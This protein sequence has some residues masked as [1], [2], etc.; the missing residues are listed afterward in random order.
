MDIK[1]TDMKLEKN[2]IVFG[3]VIL[4]MVLFIVGYA[5]MALGGDEEGRGH[6]GHDAAASSLHLHL[7][8]RPEG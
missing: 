7:H 1:Q 5:M 3:L 4:C 8:E 6:S 2:K